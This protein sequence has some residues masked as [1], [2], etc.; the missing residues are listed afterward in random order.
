MPDSPGAMPC[1]A[2]LEGLAVGIF[3]LPQVIP[4]PGLRLSVQTRPKAL[5]FP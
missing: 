1:A 5:C 4:Q 3:H 2:L